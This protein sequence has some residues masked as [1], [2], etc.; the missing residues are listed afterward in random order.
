MAT[1]PPQLCSVCL[2]QGEKPA[3]TTCWTAATEGAE[4]QSWGAG[5]KACG[6][7]GL[8]RSFVH[9]GKVAVVL[10]LCGPHVSGISKVHKCVPMSVPPAPPPH[11]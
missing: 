3:W 1:V 11:W 10:L 7:K 8:L 9:G 5:L 2:K 4:G 6:W